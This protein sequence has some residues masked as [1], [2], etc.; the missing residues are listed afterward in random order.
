MVGSLNIGAKS[1]SLVTAI[2]GTYCVLDQFVAIPSRFC[3]VVGAL[4]I[5]VRI[6][7]AIPA[8]LGYDN[9]DIILDIF[10]KEFFRSR[11]HV[12]IV[13]IVVSS[14]LDS[15]SVSDA[16]VNA[17]FMSRRKIIARHSAL[18]HSGLCER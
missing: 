8:F 15:A 14:V 2:F 10:T 13:L 3:V 18:F 11:N 12:V 4:D 7:A 1:R 9:R 16:F 5:R 6:M 17:V